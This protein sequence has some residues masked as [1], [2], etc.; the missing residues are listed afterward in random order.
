MRDRIVLAI[1]RKLESRF[2]EVRTAELETQYRDMDEFVGMLR[3]ERDVLIRSKYYPTRKEMKRRKI[4]VRRIWLGGTGI[5]RFVD[6]LK[7]V[8][9]NDPI[10]VQLWKD[11]VEIDRLKAR[12]MGEAHDERIEIGA[13]KGLLPQ[14]EAKRY[15]LFGG[16]GKGTKLIKK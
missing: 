3:E 15:Q 5:G 10:D 12:G 8:D 6:G 14:R 4:P 7:T 13:I 2:R 16:E 9:R 1:V 11:D